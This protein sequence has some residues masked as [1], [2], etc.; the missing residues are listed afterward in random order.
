[1][2]D[3]KERSSGDLPP[4]D[5]GESQDDSTL[6]GGWWQPGKSDDRREHPR[7]TFVA[8]L[9][10]IPATGVVII[11]ETLDV[12]LGGIQLRTPDKEPLPIDQFIDVTLV[13]AGIQLSMSGIVARHGEDG[14]FGVRFIDL[15]SQQRE[16]LRTIVDEA[17]RS[18]SDE[19]EAAQGSYQIKS[20]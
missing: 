3:E 8:R 4:F 5:A 2:S 11:C 18:M 14:A 10:L 17:E 15:E 1:M 9:S 13:A 20:S 12:S 16:T 6:A 7:F 19:F